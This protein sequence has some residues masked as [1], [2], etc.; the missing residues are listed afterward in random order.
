MPV[1]T[2]SVPTKAKTERCNAALLPPIAANS[3]ISDTLTRVLGTQASKAASTAP[4]LRLAGTYAGAGGLKIKF[5]DD[6]ATVECGEAH[7]A[8]AYSVMPAGGEFAVKLQ[9]GATPFTLAF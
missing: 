8:E 6:S 2:Y 9:N 4:G 5:R 7:A 3:K 1:H